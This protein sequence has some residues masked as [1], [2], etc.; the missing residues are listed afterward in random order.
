MGMSL[1]SLVGIFLLL[2]VSSLWAADSSH[3]NV[4][5][6]WSAHNQE[7]MEDSNTRPTGLHYGIGL[8]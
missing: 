7:S 2:S 8:G 1:R 3:V 6:G 4:F 5:G